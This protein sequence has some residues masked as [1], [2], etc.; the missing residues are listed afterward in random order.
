MPN[1]YFLNHV[2]PEEPKLRTAHVHPHKLEDEGNV[3]LEKKKNRDN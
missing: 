3:I 1:K 2:V